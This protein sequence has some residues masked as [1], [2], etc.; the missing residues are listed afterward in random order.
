MLGE[1]I[2]AVLLRP[3][4]QRCGLTSICIEYLSHADCSMVHIEYAPS[5]I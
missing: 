2:S 3:Y 4:I 1:N 5:N